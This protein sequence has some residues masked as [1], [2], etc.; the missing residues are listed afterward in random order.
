MVVMANQGGDGWRTSWPL[1]WE[2]AH[3]R[4]P[5]DAGPAYPVLCIPAPS[6]PF[7]DLPA[8][9]YYLQTGH[10][11]HLQKP[12]NVIYHAPRDCWTRAGC[13]VVLGLFFYWSITT[14]TTTIITTTTTTTTTAVA[15][16]AAANW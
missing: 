5:P 12:S 10:R 9:T 2:L 13:C 15:A 6:S 1:K 14:P 16:V 11:C 8:I 7:A 3:A 4:D